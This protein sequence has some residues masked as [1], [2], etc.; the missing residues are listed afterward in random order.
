MKIITIENHNDEITIELEGVQSELNSSNVRGFIY[1]KL[2]MLEQL[3]DMKFDIDFEYE[4]I[5]FGVV[6]TKDVFDG[7][8]EKTVDLREVT[9]TI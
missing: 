3:L 8:V 1:D 2:P 6:E 4:W 5:T 9:I 7:D